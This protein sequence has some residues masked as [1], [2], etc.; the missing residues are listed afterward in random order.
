MS[1]YFFIGFVSLFS[2]GLVA[3]GGNEV[4]EEEEVEVISESHSND[5]E[6]RSINDALKQIEASISE[7]NDGE[8]VEVIDYKLLKEI[9]P[10]KMAGLERTKHKGSKTGA[11]GFKVS[12]AEAEYEAD[13]QRIEV[14]ITDTGGIGMAKVAL[15][16]WST[17]EIDSESDDGFERSYTKDD[18]FYFEKY[19][20]DYESY[21][22][23]MLVN[24]R[25]VIDVESEKVDYKKVRQAVDRFKLNR[26][27]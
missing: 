23:K 21:E 12:S 27:Q 10:K 8:E 4:S 13:D 11:M 22:L 3:C 20:K 14:T 15:A 25:L 2:L 19:E 18:I 6:T 7:M 5:S 17:V 1:K 24:D 16:A 26:L 9:L